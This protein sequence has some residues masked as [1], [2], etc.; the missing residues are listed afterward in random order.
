[1]RPNPH[2]VDIGATVEWVDAVGREGGE[3]LGTGGAALG[4]GLIS[5]CV[6]GPEGPDTSK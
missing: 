1:M 4:V 3:T 6:R 5:G 2:L